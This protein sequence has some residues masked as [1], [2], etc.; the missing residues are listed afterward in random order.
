MKNP[1]QKRQNS[2]SV[3]QNPRL[4]FSSVLDDSHMVEIRLRETHAELETRL[5]IQEADAQQQRRKDTIF[6]S[7]TLTCS[8]LFVTICIAV[9]LLPNSSTTS[10]SW[11]REM[12]TSLTAAV[13]G[14]L[15][16]RGSSKK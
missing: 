13:C 9:I 10:L 4:H 8:L 15:F 14:Y 3:P 11:A 7:V 6:F 2:I 5:R 16:G 1:G 12:L